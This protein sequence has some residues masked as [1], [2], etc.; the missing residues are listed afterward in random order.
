MPELSRLNFHGRRMDLDGDF[1][2]PMS[3]E[4]VEEFDVCTLDSQDLVISV[5]P[6]MF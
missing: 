4:N 1:I 3:V 5:V 2:G 6:V